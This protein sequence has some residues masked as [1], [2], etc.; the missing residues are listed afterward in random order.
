MKD[1]PVTFQH[2]YSRPI[3]WYIERDGKQI[4]EISPGFE[5][6]VEDIERINFSIVP[7]YRVIKQENGLVQEV[8][9]LSFSLISE[10]PR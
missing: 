6:T 9:L 5:V 3:G 2:D 7:T 8:E 4:I 10:D 1:L